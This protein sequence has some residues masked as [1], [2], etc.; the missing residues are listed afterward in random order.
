[1]VHL[2]NQF[3]SAAG[4]SLPAG[5]PSAREEV[6]SLHN[7]RVTFREGGIRSARLEPEGIPLP[8][9]RDTAGIHVT[10]PELRVHS[11]VVAER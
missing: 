2:L 7:I 5:S 9:V 11:M 6:V 8:L 3:N 10:V 1:V 4:R